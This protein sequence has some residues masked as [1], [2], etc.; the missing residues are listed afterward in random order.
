MPADDPD[1][2]GWR[3]AAPAG[4]QKL[5]TLSSSQALVPLARVSST[6]EEVK[7]NGLA[8]VQ[9]MQSGLDSDFALLRRVGTPSEARRGP[10]G[11]R[12]VASD[13]NFAR[14]TPAPHLLQRPPAAAAGAPQPPRLTA[15][16][17]RQADAWDWLSALNSTLNQARAAQ[18]QRFALSRAG[19]E[20]QVRQRF[21][22]EDV[23]F[24]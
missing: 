1:R 2:S 10:G 22:W 20:E 3:L 19:L 7:A 9:K 24:W 14:R 12:R 16:Q 13:T 15:A 5:R 11:M 18:Q 17:Q 23:G 21:Q 6:L 4:L 8:A